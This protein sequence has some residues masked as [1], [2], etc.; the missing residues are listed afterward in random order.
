MAFLGGV[1]VF[2][3]GNVAKEDYTPGIIR[4]CH[5]LSATAARS[6]LGAHLTPELALG[7]WVAAVRELYEETGILLAVTKVGER[8]D[9]QRFEIERQA[10]VGKSLSFESFLKAHDLFCALDQ[11]VYFSHWKTPRRFSMRFDTHFYLAR[12]PEG[13]TPVPNPHEIEDA[14]WVTPDRALTLFER[15]ELPIIFPTFAS[16]RALA[17]FDSMESVFSEYGGKAARL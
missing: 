17:D 12:L 3:G 1:Y 15:E 10:L 2:P 13:Q 9:P 5:G 8:V 11:L 4:R 16:L 14:L 7:H 6:I